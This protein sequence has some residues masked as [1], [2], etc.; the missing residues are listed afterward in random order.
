MQ[1]RHRKVVD[2]YLHLL[3]QAVCITSPKPWRRITVTLKVWCWKRKSSKSNPVWRET[4]CRCSQN[5]EADA[6][7]ILPSVQNMPQ[8][9]L[10]SCTSL[11]NLCALFN[12]SDM[13]IHYVE[14]EKEE[15][16]SVVEEA[17][18][19]RRRRQALSQCEPKP[20]LVLI[21]PICSLT[22]A[23]HCLVSGRFSYLWKMYWKRDINSKIKWM[24]INFKD[25]I[26]TDFQTSWSDQR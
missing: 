11:T 24:R 22:W 15:W 21:Q 19:I 26:L 7:F 16:D 6:I 14:V 18:D 2:S 3:F 23:P 4:R 25:M 8:L 17:M 20:D 10:H 12:C 5:G 9:Q 1:L 13:S